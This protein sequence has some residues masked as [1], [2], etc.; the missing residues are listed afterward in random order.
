MLEQIQKLMTVQLCNLFGINE[1]R[2]TKDHQKKNRFVFLALAWLFVIALLIFY[3]AILSS[4][5]TKMGLAEIIPI[6]LYAVTSVIILIFSFLKAGSVIFQMKSFEMLVALPLSKTAIIISRFLTMYTTNLA[7]SF[8][9]MI[10]GTAIYGMNAHPSALF[11]IFSLV[12]TLFLPLLPMTLSTAVGALITAVGSRMKHKSLV[13]ALLIIVISV[14]FI[15]GNTVFSSNAGQFTE[16]MVRD[17]ASAMTTQIKS[18]FPPALWFGEAVIHNDI[19]ALLSLVGLS[20]IVFFIMTAFI[21]KYFMTICMA[22]NTS[23]AKNNYRMKSLQASSPLKALWRKELKRYFASSIYVSNTIMGYI[24]M[25]ACAVALLVMGP[26]KLETA[27]MYPG[28]VKRALPVFL[29]AMAALMPMTSCAISMEG[30]TWWLMQSLPVRNRDI[31]NGKILAHLSVSLPFYVISIILSWIAL[32]PS[33]IGCLWL[34]FIPAAYI[35]FSS[36]AGIAVNLAFPI[37]NWENEARV[38]KQ[39]ASTMVSMLISFVAFLPP[40]FAL[41]AFR[42]IPVNAVMA[43]T[44]TVLLVL[45]AVL[46]MI[47]S[48]KPILQ[49]N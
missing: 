25:V 1:I 6:Y 5:F 11:Y 13:S 24:L 28:I 32:K 9:I 2:H 36:V 46:Y 41:L 49:I 26:E 44:L 43:A 20:L 37:L 17:M 22:L 39:S 29:G 42:S 35:L 3:V 31:F 8:L 21:Q 4:A 45:T 14:G 33:L 7:L 12:G 27:L 38:V 30:N 18:L 10:P 16:D 48:K 47:N 23:S 19:L 40:L 34:I 15:I